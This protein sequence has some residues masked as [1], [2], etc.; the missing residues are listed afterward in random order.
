MFDPS[1]L[2]LHLGGNKS[3]PK[4]KTEEKRLL[5]FM[6]RVFTL[7][8][9]CLKFQLHVR[10]CCTQCVFLLQLLLFAFFWPRNAVE[11]R[12]CYQNVC[13]SVTLKSHGK[14]FFYTAF[15]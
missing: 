6:F 9:C 13:P 1:K 4:T 10:L 14:L 15:V 2:I 5:A 8:Q 7:C 11:R 12:I 3:R